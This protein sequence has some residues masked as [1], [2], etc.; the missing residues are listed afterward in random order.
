MISTLIEGAALYDGISNGPVTTDVGVVGDR[1]A[2]MGDLSDRETARRVDGRGLALAPG[3]IDVHSHSDE[4]WLVD[5][6]C[7]GKIAQGVTT[8]IGGNCGSSVAPLYGLAHERRQEDLAVFGLEAEWRD[9]NQFFDLVARR[10]VGLNVAT[11]VGLG[12]TRRCVRGDREGRLERE[13]LAA[14]ATYVRAAIEQ[15]A[16]GISSGLIYTPSRYADLDELAACAIEARAAGAP[17]YVSHIRSEGD[18]LLEAVDEA[19]E[20]A[21]RA[22]VAVQFS[23][24]KA[25][26]KKNWGKVHR[27]LAAID[28]ARD[29]SGIA[30]HADVYPYTASWTDLVTILPDEV[31]DGGREATLERLSDP[32]DAAAIALQLEFEWSGS[33][34]DIQ[35]TTVASAK[36]EELAGSRLDEIAQRWGLKPARAAIRL[37]IEERLEAQAIFFTMNEDDVAAVLSA[38]FTCIGSDAS[39][40]ALSGPTVRGVPH[41]RTFGCF[42]RVFGRF[43]RGRQTLETGE[44]IRRMT[45]LPADIFGLHER[46]RLA[47][48]AF[49]DMVLFDP[50]TIVDTAT[51]EKPYAYPRGLNWV[52]VNGEAVMRDGAP[53]GALP[54]RVLRAGR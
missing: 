11:L 25:A 1:I 45:S 42:A 46:G 54:G 48:G 19:L 29:R 35:I 2:L 5:P 51:Y 30:V 44:A 22:D 52:W 43:V 49:A 13:E 33:W 39:A 50:K 47:V 38:S 18:A 37:L 32:A 36:N 15:G 10:G 3:F 27:S 17:R 12:T 16:L 41:P 53:T 14:E 9:L 24:H 7:E 40:R 21:R 20:V 6:R 8:E 4:L 23:H 34:H 26:G 28:R 31:R